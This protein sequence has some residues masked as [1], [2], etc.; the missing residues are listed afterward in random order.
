MNPYESI[1]SML[2]AN[3][4]DFEEI[5]HEAVYTSEQA[6]AIRGLSLDGG[7]KSLLLKTNDDF[8]LIVLSGSKKLDSKKV[9]LALS[10]KKLRFA[11]PEEVKQHMGCEIGA[12]YP[13]GSIAKLK[14]YVD[15]SLLSQSTIS[16]NPGVHNKS[17]TLKLN[18]YLVLENPAQ[19]S[20]GLN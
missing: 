15:Q 8:V 5:E 1:L 4:I 18:D 14:T 10:T 11:T 12:C 2:R 19:V 7:A 20:I 16:F 3:G 13:F 9:K 17:I 6:A